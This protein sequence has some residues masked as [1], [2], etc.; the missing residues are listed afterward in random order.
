MRRFF[1]IAIPVFALGWLFGM[2]FWYLASPLWI[3]RI[4]D[5]QLVQSSESEVL[6]SGSFNGTDAIHQSSGEAT[7]VRQAD[8]SVELQFS[9]FSVT[10][11]PDLKV[12]LIS[13]ASPQGAGDVKA[14]V[15]LKLSQLK[16]NIGDQV[17]RIPAGTD[18]S[19]FKS[20][21]IYC[22]QF[23]FMFAAAPLG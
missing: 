3:D 6:A 8:G 11:G 5:E 12:W 2:A 17:Y 1:K 4:V 9:D 15:V 23:S 14:S 16:G 18:V 21:V 19:A 20:V 7:L 13:N 10:N 22:E